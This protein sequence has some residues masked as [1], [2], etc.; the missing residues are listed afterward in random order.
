MSQS[1]NLQ[2]EN[3]NALIQMDQDWIRVDKNNAAIN[4]FISCFKTLFSEVSL[5]DYLPRLTRLR[6]KYP[7]EKRI[8]SYFSYFS[9][10]RDPNLP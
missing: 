2:N 1:T 3:M 7:K 9:S 8:K 4:K 6:C 5:I 10:K